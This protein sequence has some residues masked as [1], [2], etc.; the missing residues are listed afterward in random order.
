MSVSHHSRPQEHPSAR[1]EKK[2]SRWLLRKATD[3][4]VRVA[5]QILLVS[6]LLFF[7]AL[8]LRFLGPD[9]KAVEQVWE[10]AK[11]ECTFFTAFSLG[12]LAGRSR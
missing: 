11:F 3:N 4:P 5:K 8:V 9:T 1:Q 2:R 7:A 10:F 6:T 12:Y